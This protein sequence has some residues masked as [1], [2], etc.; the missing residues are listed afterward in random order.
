MTNKTRLNELKAFIQAQGWKWE[1][2]KSIQ[3]GEQIIV[4]VGSRRASVN[5]YYKRGRMVVGGSDSPLK[6][7]LQAWIKGLSSSTKPEPSTKSARPTVRKGTRLDELKDF[8]A[9]RGWQWG[10]GKDIPY[11]EQIVVSDAGVTAL[12]NFWPKRGKMQVQGNN[13]ALKS[14]LAAWVT[15]E[16]GQ[17]ASS[18]SVSPHIGM[19]ESGKGDWFGP[20]VVAAVYVDSQKAMALRQIGV[21]DS[22]TFKAH[23]IQRLAGEIERQIPS[24]WRH[25]WVIDLERYNELYRKHKNINL[26]LADAYAQV[27]QKVWQATQAQQIVCDQFSKRA[28]RLENAFAAQGLPRPTQQ[29]RAESASIAVAAAS[30]LASAAFA[31]ALKELGQKAALG[32]PLPKGSS[33]KDKLEAAARLIIQIQGVEALGH[34]A[35]LHFK[36]IQNLLQKFAPQAIP[37]EK[38][39]LPV[40]IEYENWRVQYDPTDF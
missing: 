16:S 28:D 39:G 31:D 10:T 38:S 14:A 34:Y 1:S 25:V 6:Q 8:I 33:K 17:V 23:E 29:H 11:G 2:G 40:T 27:A 13:S 36:P 21:R 24:E 26:L 5:F 30:I 32:E 3:Y 35:K 37:T 20:L 18:A 9:E 15:G 4:S 22:K 7:A 19:D 12:V